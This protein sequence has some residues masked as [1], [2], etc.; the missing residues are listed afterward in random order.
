MSLEFDD[1]GT[2]VTGRNRH[3]KSGRNIP[4][5]EARLELC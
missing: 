1:A 3:L 5:I 2:L 4:V